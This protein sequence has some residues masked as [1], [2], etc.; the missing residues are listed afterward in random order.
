MP[1]LIFRWYL[2]RLTTA[3]FSTTPSSRNALSPLKFPSRISIY[4]DNPQYSCGLYGT[5]RNWFFGVKVFFSFRNRQRHRWKCS[6]HVLF[7]VP[8]VQRIR[9]KGFC[10]KEALSK[11]K[12]GSQAISSRK[13]VMADFLLDRRSA[14]GIFYEQDWLEIWRRFV[15]QHYRVKPGEGGYFRKGWPK[16]LARWLFPKKE[17]DQWKW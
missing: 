7:P 13:I 11:Y 12:K 2:S 15:R 6:Q 8:R 16:N 10:M 3:K 4:D 17:G 14:I 5:L 9:R 1:S